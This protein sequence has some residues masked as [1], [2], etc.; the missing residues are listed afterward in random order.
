MPRGAGLASVSMFGSLQFQSL[1][2]LPCW[3]CLVVPDFAAVREA[4][5]VQVDCKPD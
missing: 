5:S 1:R 2:L 3:P 4:V